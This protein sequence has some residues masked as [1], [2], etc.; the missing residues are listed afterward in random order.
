MGELQYPDVL[1]W[2]I[3]VFVACIGIELLWLKRHPIKNAYTLKDAATSL[4]MGIGMSLSNIFLGFIS[5]AILL[6]V[7]QFRFFDLGTSLGIVLL[8]VL[9]YD[10]VFYVKH[11]LGHKSRWFWAAHVVHH[12]SEHYNLTTA[13]RQPWTNHFT[14]IVLL[15]IPMVLL[16]FHPLL[17][18]FVGGVNLLY[19]FWFHTE[20]IDKMP[21]WYEFIFNTPSHHRVH[22]GRNPRYLD[23]NYAGILIIW[24]RIFGTFVPETENDKADYGIVV[25]LKSH[26]PLI[27]A[28]H[29]YA[30]IFK[31]ITQPGLSLG[32]RIKLIFAPPGTCYD[33]SKMTAPEIKAE[34][35]R[36][37]PDQAGTPGFTK[38]K[39]K[40]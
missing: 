24:D 31:D 38:L 2:A 39:A 12:S 35:V 6:W 40:S 21:R 8:A 37:H 36:Q 28:F 25:P 13:L 17:V 15:N 10:F 16:G 19:Q 27:V 34:Y 14:G 22:H 1:L 3:P 18:F 20:T 30:A 5:L 32:Q 26:N 7:W 33:D 11:W 9:I 4:S 23:A 29:E